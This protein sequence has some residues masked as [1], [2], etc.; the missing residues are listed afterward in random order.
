MV[1]TTCGD[2]LDTVQRTPPHCVHLGAR[3][4]EARRKGETLDAPHAHAH[5][6][7]FP[8][9]P[10]LLHAPHVTSICNG[11][12]CRSLQ[13]ISPRSSSLAC[14]GHQP[15]ISIAMI[16]P[17]PARAER[18]VF[19]VGGHITDFCGKGSPKFDGGEAEPRGLK[20]YINE[21]VRGALESV[22]TTGAAVDRMYVGNFAGE[23]FNSQG[24][25]GAAL[26]VADRA[27]I[28]KPSLRL[29]AACASG[30]LACSESV[31]AIRAGDDC[32]MAVGVEVQ[33]AVDARTG[34][35]FLARAADY[36]RQSGI[37][38]FLFPALFARRVKAYTER[39]PDCTMD[40][41]ALVA[42]KAYANGNLNPKAHMHRRQLSLEKAKASPKF[43][44]N[45][46]YRP[47]L[48][49]SDCSQ[50]S[51][52]GAA[53]IFMSEE[54]MRSHGISPNDTVEVLASDQGAGDL[55][56]DPEDLTE[57]SSV[58]TVVSRMLSKAKVTPQQLDVAEV[59]D[60]FAVSELLMYEAIGL[61]EPGR[62]AE[63]FR[64][65][66]TRLDGSIP[67]NT[68]GGL[69][70]FGHPVGATGVKQVLEI[71][72]QMKGR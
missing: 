34:G 14:T 29:E 61:A 23:L 19:L 26:A 38:D 18:K 64:T 43:L 56:A 28:N 70:S 37:D 8:G 60:C 35:T 10:V 32:V 15:E 16:D 7:A 49:V 30:G 31:R 50:V 2:G 69:L 57:L 45:Q 40:D 20:G 65:G 1:A 59:H 25:L 71:Y 13:S 48:R 63:F 54:C 39:Y 9:L 46:E 72:N 11:T 47:Y 42:A 17:S 67:V 3:K 55:W 5:A 33:N 12:A 66:A 68:G 22:G 62:G 52:G 27:L 21:A 24:H 6:H 58:R 4:S 36:E 44:R 51:D 41:I 53:A